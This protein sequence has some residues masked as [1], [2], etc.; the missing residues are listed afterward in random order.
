MDRE[1]KSAD[2]VI[3]RAGATTIAELTAAGRAAIL[4]PLPTAADDHQKKNAEVLARAGAAELI[5]QKDLAGAL[6]ADRILALTGDAA[7]RQAIAQAART[8]AR[9]DAARTIVDRALELARC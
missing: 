4:I 5:E 6:L 2:L 9:P 8:F 1:M 7:R 3:S